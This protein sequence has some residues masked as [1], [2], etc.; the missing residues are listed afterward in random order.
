MLRMPGGAVWAARGDTSFDG[1]GCVV[2]I[3]ADLLSGQPLEKSRACNPLLS[4][5]PPPLSATRGGEVVPAEGGRGWG[6]AGK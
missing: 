4:P 6:E 3:I 2:G 5:R 1:C